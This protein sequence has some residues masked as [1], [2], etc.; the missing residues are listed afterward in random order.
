MRKNLFLICMIAIL[1][2]SVCHTTDLKAAQKNDRAAWDFGKEITETKSGLRY[3]AYPSKDGTEAWIYRIYG[4]FHS[5]NVTLSI[6]KTIGGRK[7]T[8]LGEAR[9]TEDYPLNIIG[10][11]VDVRTDIEAYLV[12]RI[13]K[14]MIPDTVTV[15]EPYTFA[16][17]HQMKTIKIPKNVTKIGAY[18]FYEC[19]RL[20]KVILPEKLKDFEPLAFYQCRKLKKLQ[21]S[22]KNKIF[23]VKKGRFLITGKNNALVFAA[24]GGVR[25]LQ[26]PNGIKTIRKN[27][28]SNGTASVVHIPASVQKL[29][30]S[31]FAC[32]IK[33]VTVDANN[34][35]F[36]KEDQCIYRI[37][38]KSL[39]VA[40]VD[41]NFNLRIPDAVEKLTPE[42][43]RINYNDDADNL[44]HVI[45]PSHLKS[46]EGRGLY[47]AE[48]FEVYFTGMTP[49]KVTK[50][51]KVKKE[52]ADIFFAL[53]GDVFVPK[54]SVKAYKEWYKKNG[55]EPYWVRWH[56]Y[57]G[58]IPEF[59]VE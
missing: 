56:T 39:A 53:R 15:I 52:E 7:V 31:A 58:S 59:D 38:D 26:I 57:D 30:E 12:N 51:K 27:A 36:R 40:I 8:R 46:I 35:V 11:T 54:A 10:A 20:K 42:Y 48:A 25:T 37:K 28:C 6:P 13:Q 34:P 44:E 29:E 43:S 22:S 32:Q 9:R 3:F 55:G 50:R 24:A 5:K 21:L 23:R 14:V 45:L 17:L 18:A 49:P 33:D 4:N 41:E 47:A 19:R 16:G 2:L 1:A